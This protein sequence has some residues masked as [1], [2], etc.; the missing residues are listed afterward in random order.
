MKSANQIDAENEYSK[1]VGLQQ[2]D[3][4]DLIDDNADY[5]RIIDDFKGFIRMAENDLT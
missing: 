4:H 5:L 1:L 2:Q 3:L